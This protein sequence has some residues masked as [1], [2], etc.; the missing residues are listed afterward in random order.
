MVEFIS[1]VF[2]ILN[3]KFKILKEKKTLNLL[4]MDSKK[5]I[6]IYV[7]NIFISSKI[8]CIRRF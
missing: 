2:Q 7:F 1:L 4:V 5:Y 6:Y 3:L 8:C